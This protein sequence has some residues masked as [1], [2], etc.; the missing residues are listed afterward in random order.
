[1]ADLQAYER[2]K[3]PRVSGGLTHRLGQG[4]NME[5]KIIVRKVQGKGPAWRPY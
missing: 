5:N 3:I 4:S 2:Q 1:M